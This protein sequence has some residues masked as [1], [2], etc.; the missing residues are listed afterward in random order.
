[1]KIAVFDLQ[2]HEKRMFN[3]LEPQYKIH[4][5]KESADDVNLQ[6]LKD[7]DVISVFVLSKLSAE[8]LKQFPKLK[9]VAA[10]STG[11]DNIDL[12]YCAKHKII[13]C[14]VPA[15]GEVTV[16]EHTFALLLAVSRKIQIACWQGLKK[17]FDPQPLKGFDLHSKTIGVIGAGKIG[18][19]VIKIAHGFG[20]EILAYDINRDKLLAEIL[21]FKYTDLKILLKKS[22]IVT[23]HTPYNK[24]THH[25]INQKTIKMF[26]RGAI[27]I[28]TARGGLIDTNILL[29][30]LQ[31]GTLV[32]AGLDVLEEE[33]VI[34]KN[35]K[36][37]AKNKEISLKNKKLIALPQVVFTP[38]IAFN[39]QEA[40]ERITETSIENIISFHNGQAI[41]K[42]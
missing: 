21:D 20:L 29:T 28:N 31:N 11:F 26:K 12:K 7:C 37:T 5:F 24:S 34:I 25:L 8:V 18:K 10:R 42:V 6:A 16:A 33:N 1:M 36:T 17:K 27:L 13:V 19:N 41:N 35:Q 4:Y 3:K 32:A 30:A 39:T 15:Y 22:D 14:N 38:H 23:L 9:M 40:V 2:P